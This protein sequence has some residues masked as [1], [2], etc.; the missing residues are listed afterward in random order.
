MK[1]CYDN[2]IKE[3]KNI[4]QQKA[5]YQKVMLIFD[6]SVSNLL[7]SEI[8]NNIREFCVYNQS[9]IQ[10]VDLVE[11]YNGYRL[12]IFCCCVDDFLKCEVNREEFVNIYFPQDSFMLP[13][14]LTNKSTIQK[15]DD[16]LIIDHNKID[17]SMMSS[18][19]FNMFYNY[20]KNLLIGQNQL[21]D[22]SFN[23]EIS[24]Y[25]ILNFIN[26]MKEDCFFLDVD[27]LKKCDLTYDDIILI[28]LLIVD[29][30]LLLITSVKNQ[31]L[32]IVDVYKSAK[33]DN[34]LI[35]KFYKLYHN[36]TFVNLILLNYNCLHNYCL[37]TKQKIVEFISFCDVNSLKVE[38]VM[39]R[40]KNYA[41]NDDNIIAYLYLYDFFKV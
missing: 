5:K 14:Y 12:V 28:D 6:D 32:M 37:K 16:Y 38:S 40:I 4:V 18:V 7:I 17:L 15:R 39:K 1:I 36:E 10:D 35:E 27:I 3:I 20:F 31:N 24:Q 33:D 8:Y 41:K 19:Y 29:A 21:I 26:E 9:K 34:D 11:I 2:P 25:N 30:F 23:K 13:Y 22:F